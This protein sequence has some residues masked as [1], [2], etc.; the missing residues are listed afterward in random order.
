MPVVEE[1]RGKTFINNNKGERKKGR[2]GRGIFHGK[3]VEGGGG[4]TGSFYQIITVRR[5]I[6]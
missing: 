6:N 3:E 1:G 2:R 5:K 4:V